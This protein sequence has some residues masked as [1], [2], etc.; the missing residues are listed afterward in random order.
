[1]I[2][3]GRSIFEASLLDEACPIKAAIM[4]M[5]LRHGEIASQSSNLHFT[6]TRLFKN[7]INNNSFFHLI[8]DTFAFSAS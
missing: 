2:L 1:M 5:I 8:A 7:S 6:Q 4:E 3:A